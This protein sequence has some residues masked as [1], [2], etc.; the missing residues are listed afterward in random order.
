MRERVDDTGA[1]TT[2]EWFEESQFRVSGWRRLLFPAVF[3][4][5]L[6]TTVG[7][8]GQH[9]SGAG[10]VVGYV[11]LAAFCVAYVVAL[12]FNRGTRGRDPTLF[13]VAYGAMCVLFV[14]ETFFAHEGAFAM[15]VY[16]AVLTIAALWER[17]ALIVAGI[18]VATMFVPRF[19]PGWHAGVDTD[20]GITILVVSLAMFGFFGILRSNRAL[21]EARSEVARLAAENERTRIARDLHDLLGHSLTTITVKAGLAH[22]LASRDPERAAV[23][24]GEVE[25]LSRRALADVRAAVASYREVTL[26]GELAT[27]RELLRAAGIA[28][29]LP[30]AT[31]GVD[32]VAE[33]LFGWVLREALT[34]VVR[35]ARA[36]RCTVTLQPH[37]IEISDDGAGGVAESGTGLIGLRERVEAA[38]GTLTAEGA[39]TGGWRVR[40]ELPADVATRVTTVGA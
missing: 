24:I 6:G 15:T 12:A 13:W 2:P 10:Q 18:A 17:S 37:A 34:N 36:T 30:T 23:E 9:S 32:P 3:L 26:T 31:D 11:V 38:G 19:V 27:G 28:A 1:Y 20:A 35:H 25:Q 14:V 29:D 8:I 7:D 21:S 33:E 39:L 16:I 4:V 40:V 22:R 5:Y